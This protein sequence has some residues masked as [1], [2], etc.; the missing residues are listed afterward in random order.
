MLLSEHE[1]FSR[2]RFLRLFIITTQK[3]TEAEPEE[4]LAINDHVEL[5]KTAITHDGGF[6]GNLMALTI[7]LS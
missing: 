3:Y 4:Q 5:N 7:W 6:H 2:S 1:K